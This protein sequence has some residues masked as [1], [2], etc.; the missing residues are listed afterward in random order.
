VTDA[1]NRERQARFAERIREQGLVK[2]CEWIPAE[3][4][5]DLKSFA[6]GLRGD[7]APPPPLATRPKRD[8]AA[9][10]VR[11]A[12]GWGWTLDAIAAYAGITTEQV[13]NILTPTGEFP[14][15]S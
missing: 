15:K 12:H 11:Q 9:Y 4:R 14:C 13:E 10:L 6:A 5:D 1:T 3:R 7:S 8:D 2:I